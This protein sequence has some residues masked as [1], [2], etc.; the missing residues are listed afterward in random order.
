MRGTA[1]RLSPPS[2]VALKASICMKYCSFEWFP[3][4]NLCEKLNLHVVQYMRNIQVFN[5]ISL[6]KS[7]IQL[8]H[9]SRFL[10]IY[11]HVINAIF[12]NS[13]TT[14]NTD[15]YCY[16]LPWDLCESFFCTRPKRAHMPIM[17][18]LRFSYDCYEESSFWN[19][20]TC[21]LLHRDQSWGEMCCPNFHGTGVI[22]LQWGK[23]QEVVLTL[24]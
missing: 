7:Q 23:K 12:L 1:I 9:S 24:R 2:A 3:V 22:L 5:N 18:S 11:L 8:F 14:C 21:S 20:T 19:V 4:I 10:C 6:S 17:R 13:Q 15:I 16:F